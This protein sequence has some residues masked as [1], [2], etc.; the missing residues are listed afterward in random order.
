M[1]GHGK[2]RPVRR[3]GREA[4]GDITAAVPDGVNNAIVWVH[5]RQG[6]YMQTPIIV[7]NRQY[8]CTDWGVLTCFDSASG[9]VIYSE[10]L[11]GPAQ[12]NTASPVAD[13]RHLFFPGETT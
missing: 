4:R 9:E 11:G 10:R 3:S 13:G 5:P 6:N 12:G 1:R 7:S 2:L 8:G